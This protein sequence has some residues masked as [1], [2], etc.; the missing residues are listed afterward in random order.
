[1]GKR[2]RS[3]IAILG[4]FQGSPL[5][6]LKQGLGLCLP[7]QL[8]EQVGMAWALHDPALLFTEGRLLHG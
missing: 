5:G 6:I 7:C 8:W 3:L 4:V 2:P 1:M